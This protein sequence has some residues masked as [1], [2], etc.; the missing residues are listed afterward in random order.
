[1][2]PCILHIVISA[3]GVAE[4]LPLAAEGGGGW[5]GD[6]G[7]VLRGTQRRTGG[8]RSYDSRG[9]PHSQGPPGVPGPGPE[10]GGP[11]GHG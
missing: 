2:V 9:R 10:A 7:G 8:G 6:R 1:M 11:Q 3:A 4:D 5:G